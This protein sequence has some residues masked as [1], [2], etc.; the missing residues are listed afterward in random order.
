MAERRGR[1]V[2]VD[3]AAIQFVDEV[4]VALLVELDALVRRARDD[5]LVHELRTVV[6]G[7][8]ARLRDAWRGQRVLQ[9]EQTTVRAG[10]AAGSRA[11]AFLCRDVR[12]PRRPVRRV[13]RDVAQGAAARSRRWRSGSSSGP[14]AAH[15]PRRSR[16]PCTGSDP[17]RAC[18][19]RRDHV[20]VARIRLAS[21]ELGASRGN[22][23]LLDAGIAECD[24]AGLV[25][26]PSGRLNQATVQIRESGLCGE[27]R[28]TGNQQTA[29][30]GKPD[31]RLS[32]G[33]MWGPFHGKSGSRASVAVPISPLPDENPMCAV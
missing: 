21:S 33:F 1:R 18:L 20:E 19:V 6:A 9:L 30:D 31:G 28:G 24:R 4:H 16:T 27:C 25:V 2:L 15:R 5:V 32:L 22:R 7:C 14:Y 11:P 12:A 3:A 8:G 17:H 26:H 29:G 23:T 13:E 10:R